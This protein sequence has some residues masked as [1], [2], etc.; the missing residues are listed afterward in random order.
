M[1]QAGNTFVA[2]YDLQNELRSAASI[3][4]KDVIMPSTKHNVGQY[5]S[6]ALDSTGYPSISYTDPENGD[7]KYAEYSI[8]VGGYSGVGVTETV[9]EGAFSIGT[10]LKLDSLGN[11]KISFYQA[12]SGD[13][14]LARYDGNTWVI[15]T[16]DSAGDVGKYSSLALD[17]A[18]NPR[19]SYYDE[20]GMNLKY[21]KLEKGKWKIE[22]V[23]VPGNV[24]IYSSLGLDSAGSP[25]ISYHDASNKDLK[26]ATWI[27]GGWKKE[28]VD[29]AGDVGRFSSLKIDSANT[30]HI[31][32]YDNSSSQKQD[33][34]YAAKTN[35][36][37]ATW[38]IQTV[39]SEND[40]GQYSSLAIDAFGRPSISYYDNTAGDLKC[41]QFFGIEWEISRIDQFN[42][43]GM[44][45]SL[46][47]DA[48]GL[49]H[50]SY[51]DATGGQLKY[52]WLNMEDHFDDGNLAGWHVENPS[53][54]AAGGKLSLVDSAAGP[55]WNARAMVV[56][57]RRVVHSQFSLETTFTRI[58]GQTAGILLRYQDSE[59]ATLASIPATDWHHDHKGS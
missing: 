22:F 29:S 48:F 43:V 33:L 31:S 51:Y 24:G 6:I 26:L 17:S 58:S 53:C 12:G 30:V 34:K 15:Q 59:E 19:I 38:T 46:A 27:E 50:M 57:E 36:K 56:S 21:A 44:F 11:P 20:S 55:A 1:D 25:R 10:S 13:L 45:S 18:G 35:L 8:G 7:L 41:A 39:D 54:S 23:D 4:N 49:P 16:V 52:I 47:L 5:T 14:K 2:A 9:V 37:K 40:V 3:W 32:Y 28:T 42:N